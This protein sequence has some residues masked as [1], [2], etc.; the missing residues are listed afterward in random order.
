LGTS[1][2]KIAQ[3]ADNIQVED[4]ILD[5]LDYVWYKL[6]PDAIKRIENNK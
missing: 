3:E 4:S 5:L 2:L 1:A 6:T